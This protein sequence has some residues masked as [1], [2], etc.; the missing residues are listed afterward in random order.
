MTPSGQGLNPNANV[1]QLKQQATAVVAAVQE[2][3]SGT[4]YED[5]SA[6]LLPPPHISQELWDA[7]SENAIFTNSEGN[8]LFYCL[9]NVD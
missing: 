9:R 3:N 1:F 2:G 7:P 5:G 6:A 8:I 4:E